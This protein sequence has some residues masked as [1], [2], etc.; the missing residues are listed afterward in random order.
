MHRLR[1]S[2][3]VEALAPVLA[4]RLQIP[5]ARNPATPDLHPDHRPRAIPGLRLL[6]AI[7]DLPHRPVAPQVAMMECGI[8]IR[9]TLAL[10]PPQVILDPLGPHPTPDLPRH[11][12]I[13]DLDLLRAALQ[14]AMTG[15]GILTRSILALRAVMMECGIPT[16]S[17][18]A[19]GHP[20]ALRTVT[21]DNH[22][23]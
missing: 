2:S 4:G 13:L 6:Q 22:N 8:L 16:K 23:P 19:L 1:G 3:A 7:L 9:S 10:H 11:Q 12:A 20:L 14:E 21:R 18:P 15:C 5:V 17:T